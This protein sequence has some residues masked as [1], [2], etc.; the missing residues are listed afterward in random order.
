MDDKKFC[1]CKIEK[2]TFLHFIRW[3][4]DI[5]VILVIKSNLRRNKTFP[6]IYIS[7][8]TSFQE[9][10]MIFN[11]IK[12]KILD[13]YY[14][15]QGL[16]ARKKVR[17]SLSSNRTGFR[18]ARESV[19]TYGDLCERLCK[20]VCNINMKGVWVLIKTKSQTKKFKRKWQNQETWYTIHSVCIK[21]LKAT[22][23]SLLLIKKIRPQNCR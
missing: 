1:Y 19:I 15:L 5:L 13:T 12:I 23:L 6:R 10:N 11:K 4:Y 7:T 9:S 20:C 3:I 18:T 21:I 22:K 14:I 2:L 8:S 16:T 17:K